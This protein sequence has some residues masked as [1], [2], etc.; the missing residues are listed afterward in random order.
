MKRKAEAVVHITHTEYRKVI[1][2][3][4]EGGGSLG[5]SPRVFP[6]EPSAMKILQRRVRPLQRLRLLK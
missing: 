1:S 6:V 4:A 2:F 5:T 3:L